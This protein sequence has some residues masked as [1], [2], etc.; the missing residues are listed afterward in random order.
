MRHDYMLGRRDCQVFLQREF[1]LAETNKRVFGTPWSAAQKQQYVSGI[2]PAGFL[3]IIPLTGTA[4]LEQQLDPWPAGKLDPERY[5]RAI[6]KRYRALLRVATPNSRW[7]RAAAWL[8]ARVS[9]GS[10]ADKVI[11][12]INTALVSASLK[13]PPPGGPPGPAAPPPGP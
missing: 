1:I 2:T 10:V 11:E 13:K 3:P 5:R 4:A 9:D 6:E 12:A 7:L 8:G